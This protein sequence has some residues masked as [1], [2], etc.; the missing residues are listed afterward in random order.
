MGYEAIG[1]KRMIK[2]NEADKRII[3]EIY[4]N[5][6]PVKE[7]ASKFGVS[8]SPIYKILTETQRAKHLPRPA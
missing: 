5:K 1:D 2:L 4:I 7:I 6:I 8:P 3:E